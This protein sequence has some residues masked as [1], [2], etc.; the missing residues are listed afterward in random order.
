MTDFRNRFRGFIRE[1]HVSVAGSVATLEPY[2]KQK[3]QVEPSMEADA[4]RLGGCN[5]AK[6]NPD[7]SARTQIQL[8]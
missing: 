4:H 6:V 5:R 7:F 2:V 1:L 8:F 3:V